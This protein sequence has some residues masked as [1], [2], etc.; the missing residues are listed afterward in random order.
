MSC[1]KRMKATGV[2]IEINYHSIYNIKN[3]NYSC[4]NYKNYNIKIGMEIAFREH[5]NAYNGKVDEL[6]CL[7]DCEIALAINVYNL[8]ISFACVY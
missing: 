2:R 3:W 8:F 6:K 1:W 5:D 4:I 7:S